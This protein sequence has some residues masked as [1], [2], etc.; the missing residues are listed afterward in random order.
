MTPGRPT[1][2][3]RERRRAVRVGAVVIAVFVFL[4]VYLLIRPSI[5]PVT[6][7]SVDDSWARD[8]IA[9]V[10]DAIRLD[11]APPTETDFAVVRRA[12]ALRFDAIAVDHETVFDLRRNRGGGGVFTAV[13]GPRR[14]PNDGAADCTASTLDESGDWQPLAAQAV[15]NPHW[16]LCDVALPGSEDGAADTRSVRFT[17]REPDVGSYRGFRFAVVDS[18]AYRLDDGATTDLRVATDRPPTR[19]LVARVTGFDPDGRVQA[20]DVPVV[21]K[22][23]GSGIRLNV[24]EGGDAGPLALVLL[25]IPPRS[26][27]EKLLGALVGRLIPQ[28]APDDDSPS[29]VT[30]PAL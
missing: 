20:V 8:R 22:A 17:R 14:R 18:R 11:A 6:E 15:A 21:R 29:T 2:D 1:P 12:D 4:F 27:I 10:A 30:S 13:L 26:A 23:G 16:V 24:A 19:H 5:A 3:E 25:E 28:A 7:T 9:R